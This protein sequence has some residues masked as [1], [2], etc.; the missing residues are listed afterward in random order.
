MDNFHFVDIKPTIDRKETASIKDAIFKRAREKAE[1]LTEEKAENYTSQVQKDVM[2]IA[3]E[4]IK[5]SPMNPFNQ[6]MDN[7][8]IQNGQPVA[9]ENTQPQQV[10][11][12]EKLKET[13]TRELKRNIESV[14]SQAFENSV[15]EETMAEARNQFRS[16]LNATLSFLNT[17][18][19]IRAAENAHSKINFM[20]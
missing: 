20:I 16:N 9:S 10:T 1:A 7:L 11:D 15:K 13:Y 2:E 17:Q 18:A 4:T 14:S 6:F 12:T 8:G 3:R 19:A 5:P